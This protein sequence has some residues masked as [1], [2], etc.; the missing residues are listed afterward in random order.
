M[1]ALSLAQLRAHTGRL[2]ATGLAI[3]IAV[4]FVVATL[5]LNQTSKTTVL[6]AVAAQ[7][8]TTDAVI[9][10]D[11][12]AVNFTPL[13]SRKGLADEVARMPGV[14]AVAADLSTYTQARLPDSTGYRS[15]RL[16]AVAPDRVLQWQ[17]LTAGRLPAATGEIAVGARKGLRLGTSVTLLVHPAG[18]ADDADPV[19]RTAVVVGLVDLKGATGDAGPGSVQL[20]ATQ[21]QARAWGADDP[22]AIRVAGTSGTDPK[23]LV[24]RVQTIL[25]RAGRLDLV[26]RTGE[27]QAEQTASDYTRDAAGLTQI[28]LVFGTVAVLVCALVIANTFTVLLAQRTRELA[29]L[30]CVGAAGGQLRRGVLIESLIIGAVASLAGVA[31]GIGLA[32]AISAIS[33]RFDSPIPLSGV[34]VPLSAV[35]IGMAI[36]IVVTVVAAFVPA[37]RATRVP[38]LAALRPMDPAPARSRA[39]LLRRGAGIA[40]LVPS[41]AVLLK[42]SL[43][44]KGSLEIGLAGGVFSFLAVILLAQWMV[45]PAVALAGRLAGPVGGIPGR[46]AASNALRN[47]QRTAATATALIIGV[48]LTATMVVGAATTRATATSGLNNKFPTDILV[49]NSSDHPLPA[50]IEPAVAAVPNVSHALALP[51]ALIKGPG[52]DVVTL[53]VDP[54]RAP[55]V[56]RSSGDDVPVAGTVNVSENVARSWGDEGTWVKL[57]NGSHRLNLMVH[58]VSS[59]T[60][61]AMTTADLARLAPGAGI[62]AVWI[63]LA[64]TADADT[65]GAALDAVTTAVTDLAPSSYTEGAFEQRDSFDRVVT[66]LLLIVT[67]LLAIAVIIAVIG[68]GNTMALSV[69]ERRQESGL[70]RALGLTRGQLRWM[71]LWEALLIAGVAS[72]LGTALGI[73]Y[74][75]LGTSAALRGATTLR[76]SLPWGQLLLIVV[77]ATAAGAVASVLPSRRAAR[78][79]P[80]AAIAA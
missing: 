5:V 40:L 33:S 15:A 4:G 17:R 76:I 10:P 72:L 35:A 54:A 14:R 1:F 39:G 79:S 2:L 11:P 9:T 46:L 63:R 24:A 60:P 21:G 19:T 62:G 61:A 38:P 29:L 56:V 13:G 43:T 51:S 42:G 12:D 53:G 71:L 67:G 30:R 55:A 48:T 47:P 65:R 3:I 23:A 32:G 73:G 16:T 27:Q 25:D 66:T 31:A 41:V 68:V 77:V 26:V 18:S 74:G 37:R 6:G 7:Y 58:V 57:S 49:Q 36:G 70:L 45:P 69:L 22:E 80:V 52:E 59:D 8:R 44:G 20:F 64:D 50:G 28:L 34:S 78:T 75:L